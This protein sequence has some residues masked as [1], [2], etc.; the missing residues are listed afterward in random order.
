[1]HFFSSF[2][3][4]CFALPFPVLEPAHR[5]SPMPEA[6]YR[7]VTTSAPGW[8]LFK[9]LI[10]GK[11]PSESRGYASVHLP[12]HKS[13]I[14][15]KL[16]LHLNRQDCFPCNCWKSSSLC[17]YWQL[18]KPR[19]NLEPT[20]MS[21][22]CI[23]QGALSIHRLGSHRETL[24]TTPTDTCGPLCTLVGGSSWP[25]DHPVVKCFFCLW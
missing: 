3:S 20:G 9:V 17:H 23:L 12:N 7:R 11:Q 6:L 22:V 13:K 15:E 25:V 14:S 5:A 8:S 1:M 2:L 24:E 21:I 16:H 19:G 18:H 10:S 4:F